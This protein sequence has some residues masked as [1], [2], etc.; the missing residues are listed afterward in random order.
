MTHTLKY[1]KCS[2]D[3]FNKLKAYSRYS[4]FWLTLYMQ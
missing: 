3:L 4:D 1:E 2:Y